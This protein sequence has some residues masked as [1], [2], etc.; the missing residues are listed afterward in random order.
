MTGIQQAPGSVLGALTQD[1][2]KATLKYYEKKC[3]DCMCEGRLREANDS[4]K[5][6]FLSRT[7]RF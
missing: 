2:T 6:T 3:L 5:F 4:P 1:L 7:M